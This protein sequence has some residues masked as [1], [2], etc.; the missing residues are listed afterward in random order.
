VL[1]LGSG[2]VTHN[3]Q[4][5]GRSGPHVAEF[6]DWICSAVEQ[7]RADDLVRWE[8]IAPHAKRNHPTPEHLLP[9]FAPLGASNGSLGQV[10]NRVFEYG[11]LSMAIFTWPAPP[12]SSQ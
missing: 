7:G 3:L 1:I 4:E 5:I 10:L 9:M 12:W 6:D 8:E 2:S 11:S